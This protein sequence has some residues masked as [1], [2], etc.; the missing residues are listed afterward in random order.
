MSEGAGKV[1]EIVLGAALG[2]AVL[3][4]VGAL[5]DTVVDIH[6]LDA[7]LQL[8]VVGGL[9]VTSSVLIRFGIAL[10]GTLRL[11]LRALH[12]LR[13]GRFEELLP[14]ARE[15]LEEAERVFG[16]SHKLTTARR[17]GLCALHCRLG[18]YEEAR[19]L[20]EIN[21]RVRMHALGPDHPDTVAARE[22]AE[23]VWQ[24]GR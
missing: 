11:R 5:V 15:L 9:A 16:Y 14:L 21:L 23:L 17:Q 18:E 1:A 13:A 8:L 22:L 3:V 6:A 2:L 12:L 20:A 10:V 24:V 7:G 19:G 4:G